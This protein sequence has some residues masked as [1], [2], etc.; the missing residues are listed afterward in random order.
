MS[1]L[2]ADMGLLLSAEDSAGLRK[3]ADQKT[4][5]LVLSKFDKIESSIAL[6]MGALQNTYGYGASN[7]EPRCVASSALPDSP[8]RM[9]IRCYTT[10]FLFYN[11]G[12]KMRLE[13]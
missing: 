12:A 8:A 4:E 1:A 6:L 3:T 11:I 9:S 2:H 5:H 7:R 10:G 13:L